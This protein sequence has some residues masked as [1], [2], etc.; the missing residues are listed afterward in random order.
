MCVCVC[1]LICGHEIMHCFAPPLCERL[2]QPKNLGNMPCCQTLC[3]ID[4]ETIKDYDFNGS[5]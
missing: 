3:H 1:V 2:R 5:L 4:K